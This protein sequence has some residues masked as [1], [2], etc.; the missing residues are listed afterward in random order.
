MAAIAWLPPLG[1]YVPGKVVALL[2]AMAMLRRVG[3]QAAVAASVV[4]MLD[5]LAVLTGLIVAT[6]T[7]LHPAIVAR[8]GPLVYTAVACVLVGS[9][10]L[11]PHVFVRLLN[12]LLKKMKRSTIPHVPSVIEYLPTIALAF[13][14][15]LFAGLALWCMCRAFVPGLAIATLGPLI[16][17]AAGAMTISY[18]VL[19]SP[20]G[21]GVREGIY[22]FIL[23]LLLGT[24][25]GP[26][27]A[28]IVPAM[29]LWQTIIEVVL[30]S[31][32]AAI[33]KSDPQLSGKT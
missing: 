9:V 30:A 24:G 14:Q 5:A 22:L 7:L 19:I 4:L 20:G 15:W 8:Y 31:L 10:V 1:K 32:G 27:V 2:G 12:T 21:V 13:A 17:A 18:L 28:L 6:P 23:P 25:S 16:A 3:V 11:H 33:L 29:R 26:A